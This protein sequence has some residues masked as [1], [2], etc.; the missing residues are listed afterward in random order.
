MKYKELLTWLKAN[1][2]LRNLDID[3]L[4]E[5]YLK[6]KYP[7]DIIQKIIKAIGDFEEVPENYNLI[8]SRKDD[9]VK[10]RH[11]SAILIR[12]NSSKTLDNIVCYFGFKN[13]STIIHSHKVIDNLLAT[14]KEF[15]IKFNNYL[16][17]LNLKYVKYGKT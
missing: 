15:R 16:K 4:L 11:I 8:N 17:Y 9:I 12:C 5:K 6:E 3:I 7:E 13:K 14:D 1:G 2:Y 10:A